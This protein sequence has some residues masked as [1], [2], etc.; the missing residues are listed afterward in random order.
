MES[1][2]Q[3]VKLEID[4]LFMFPLTFDVD[5]PREIDRIELNSKEIE[6]QSFAVES[7]DM[8]MNHFIRKYIQFSQLIYTMHAIDWH[9]NWWSPLPSVTCAISGKPKIHS[10]IQVDIHQIHVTICGSKVHHTTN[11]SWKRRALCALSAR[12]CVCMGLCEVI[13]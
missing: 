11:S 5:W 1:L 3:W 9:L 13:H 2:C 10:N 8:R 6:I 12:A 7:N 4:T